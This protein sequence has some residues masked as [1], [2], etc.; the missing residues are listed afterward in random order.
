VEAVVAAR[1]AGPP[2]VGEAGAAG[3]DV[4]LIKET[5]GVALNA[6]KVNKLRSLLT[7]LGIVIGVGAVIAMVALGRGA[8][9][10]VNERI[11]A[12]GTTLLTISPGQVSTRGVASATDRA[13]LNTDDS[14]ALVRDGQWIAAVEPE[15]GRSLQVQ[16]RSANTNTTVLGTTPNYLDVRKYTMAAGT[17][18][19]AGDDDGS[20]RV[21]VLG[22]TV[23]NNLGAGPDIVGQQIRINSIPFQ[24]IGVLAT[25]GSGGFGDPDDEVLIPLSTARFRVF[26]TKDLRAI[27]VLAPADSL[28][29]RTMVDIDRILRR[30]HHIRPGGSPD[31]QVRNQADF[32][33][34]AAATTQAFTAL[35]A[36][37]AAV[38]LIV[39]GI[40]IMNIM[41][42]SVTERTREIGVRKALGATRKNIL[43]QFLIE[44]VVLSLLG[45]FIGVC[46]GAGSAILFRTLLKWTTA[47]SPSSILLAFGFSALVGV[48]FGV[49]PARRA[50]MLSP[51]ES[52]RYE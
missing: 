8:Q 19:N 43:L 28:M 37:I 4:M 7:M 24:V 15:M 17:M 31:F 29:T 38:S 30:S 25:K 46:L 44:S 40:G 34:T 52:L 21:A 10:S 47:I 2:P 41:L 27:G 49:W 13:K 1:A 48:V 36:G 35:L 32:L 12:L 9:N 3:D 14:D 22:Q 16:Y 26:T 6:L 51:I 50:S 5:V 33:N 11:A 42:V 45:G 23:L 18:F 39:G 20:R